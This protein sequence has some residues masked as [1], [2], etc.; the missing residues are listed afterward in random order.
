M[1][2]NGDDRVFSGYPDR[3]LPEAV[4]PFL[5]QRSKLL[6]GYCSDDHRRIP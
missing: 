4:D 6:A 3:V 1:K 5:R 2:V